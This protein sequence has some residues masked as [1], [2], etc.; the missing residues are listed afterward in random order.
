MVIK[1]LQISKHPSLHN[2]MKPMIAINAI[3]I[4]VVIIIPHNLRY[5]CDDFIFRNCEHILYIA[6]IKRTV[7][8]ARMIILHG[9]PLSGLYASS[10]IIKKRKNP[11]IA[12]IIKSVGVLFNGLDFCSFINYTS[13]FWIIYS[14]KI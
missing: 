2:P 13:Q 9:I 7:F 5:C 1:L 12:K 6:I 3:N 11:T 14:N 8:K 10:K 4:V